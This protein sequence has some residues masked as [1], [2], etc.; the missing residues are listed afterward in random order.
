MQNR[1]SSSLDQ[2]SFTTE[3]QAHWVVIHNNVIS[4]DMNFAIQEN[5]FVRFCLAKIAYS[6]E[7]PISVKKVRPTSVRRSGEALTLWSSLSGRGM[8]R[9][10]PLKGENQSSSSSSSR[11]RLLEAAE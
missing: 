6:H 1:V 8:N 10:A 5:N 11:L 2:N 4:V 3:S 7:P 9:R